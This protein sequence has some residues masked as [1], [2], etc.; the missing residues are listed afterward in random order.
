M[1]LKRVEF[2]LQRLSEKIEL[3]FFDLKAE[4]ISEN[5]LFG[6]ETKPLKKIE[7]KLSRIPPE[8]EKEFCSFAEK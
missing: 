5:S 6:T 3:K 1:F 4:E 2:A 8:P 7:P